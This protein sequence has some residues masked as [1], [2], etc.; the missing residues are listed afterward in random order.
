[1][2]NADSHTTIGSNGWPTFQEKIVG[3]NKRSAVPACHA[4][5]GSIPETGESKMRS[6]D[7]AIPVRVCQVWKEESGFL[8]SHSS[9]TWE[10]QFVLVSGIDSNKG[11]WR[12]NIV[13]DD[14]GCMKCIREN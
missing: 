9:R 6:V 2:A 14:E 12:C 3:R 1:M 4:G 7:E 10:L 5:R 13:N 8:L 11:V